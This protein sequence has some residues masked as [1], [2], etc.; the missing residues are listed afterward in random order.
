MNHF[1]FLMPNCVDLVRPGSTKSR[2]VT[3]ISFNSKLFKGSLVAS[4]ALTAL[5]EREGAIFALNCKILAG[6]NTFNV[7]KIV[8]DHSS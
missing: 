6:F 4:E 8:R 1:S 7:A 2:A 5:L 3:H